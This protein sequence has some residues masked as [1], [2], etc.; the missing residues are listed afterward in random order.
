MK[1]N[2]IFRILCVATLLGSYTSPPHARETIDDS[3]S[4]GLLNRIQQTLPG[5][6][7]NFAQVSQNGAGRLATDLNIRQ[8]FVE[9]EPVFIF[10]TR[11]RGVIEANF[12][13]Y[14][15]KLNPQTKLP[16]LHFSHLSGSELSLSMQATLETAWKRVLPGCVIVLEDSGDLIQGHSEPDT[17]RFGDPLLGESRVYR[18]LALGKNNLRLETI[19]MAPGDDYIAGSKTLH[20]LKHQLY[21]GT[22]SIRSDTDP[23]TTTPGE[24]R[25][26]GEF[27][28]YDD[29]RINRLY[30]NS[31][32]MGFAL[33]LARL[34]RHEG[35][36]PQ[37]KLSI[38]NIENDGMQAYQ[39]IETATGQIEL[40]LEWIKVNLDLVKPD[41]GVR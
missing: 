4:N 28:I 1:L 35:E 30:E 25:T 40:N 6:Y 19:V 31:S 2:N 18:M 37:H 41:Q 21:T 9:G 5:I 23:D 8:L 32:T 15:L 24:W 22:V 20:M 26:S 27:N 11:Q 16:E 33:R 10:E 36:P 7:S 13:V 29:G 34:Y 39:W 12:D 14:W 3:D 38:I 17:C